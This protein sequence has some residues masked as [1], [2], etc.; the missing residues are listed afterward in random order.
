ME[1]ARAVARD[2]DSE[3]VRTVF[4]FVLFCD[5]WMALIV[6]RDGRQAPIMRQDQ[7]RSSQKFLNINP[8]TSTSYQQ[9]MILVI[10]VV[11]CTGSMKFYTRQ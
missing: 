5:P 6:R 3:Q 8:A 7:L 1:G 11:S 4:V 2:F 9:V 10:I